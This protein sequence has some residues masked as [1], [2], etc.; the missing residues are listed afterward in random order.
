MTRAASKS[1]IITAQSAGGP[2]KLLRA[3]PFPITV[4]RAMTSRQE[5]LEARVIAR[6]DMS[7][8]NMKMIPIDTDEIKQLTNII[9]VIT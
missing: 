2:M 3:I 4:K 1:R 6:E 5:M 7:K 8:E 9:N